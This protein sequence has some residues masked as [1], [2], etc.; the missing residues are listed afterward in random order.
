MEFQ[1]KHAT[2]GIAWI[3]GQPFQLHPGVAT[4]GARSPPEHASAN[5]RIQSSLS[6]D[7]SPAARARKAKQRL[8]RLFERARRHA[9]DRARLCRDDEY[10]ILRVA[11]QFVRAWRSEGATRK[12]DAS[13]APRPQSPSAAGPICSSW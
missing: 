8:R 1:S 5:L 13:C 10:E 6:D 2:P 4:P 9:K 12:L 11:Y 3:N 7:H